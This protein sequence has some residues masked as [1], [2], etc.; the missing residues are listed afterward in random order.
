MI[1]I[2]LVFKCQFFFPHEFLFSFSLIC[3]ICSCFSL[4]S[5]VI[6]LF[7]AIFPVVS[8]RYSYEHGLPCLYDL[9]I[10]CFL[11][12]FSLPSIYMIIG[13]LGFKRQL[14]IYCLLFPFSLPSIYM[15]IGSLFSNANFFFSCPLS[16]FSFPC[17]YMNL[18]LIIFFYCNLFFICRNNS[19]S[20]FPVYIY[21]HCFPC[22]QM[23]TLIFLSSFPLFLIT[24]FA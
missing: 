10:Y 15:I 21:D 14:L 1:I 8:W 5:I 16:S 3:I 22:F 24:V 19:S 2:F 17:I 9:L 7:F 18:F 11:F 4:F 13:S 12:S 6:S 23:S 20:L